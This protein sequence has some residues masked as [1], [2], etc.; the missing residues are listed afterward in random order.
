LLDSAI[1]WA[2]KEKMGVI[3]NLMSF[4]YFKIDSTLAAASRKEIE[5]GKQLDYWRQV[6]EYFRHYGDNVRLIL[7]EYPP[8]LADNAVDYNAILQRAFQQIR[9]I[10]TQRHFYVPVYSWK[11]MNDFRLPENSSNISVAFSLPGIQLFEM[12]HAKPWFFPHNYPRITFPAQLPDLKTYLP[13]NATA[14]AYSEKRLDERAI[15]SDFNMVKDMLRKN[16]VSFSNLYIV[17]WGYYVGYPFQPESVEDTTSIRNY[18]QAMVTQTE[19]NSI[20]WSIYDYNSGMA[21][22]DSAGNPSVLLRSLQLKKGL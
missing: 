21:I 3:F 15:E 16:K 9:L 8:D 13:E 17:N 5:L 19:R 20:N 6:T 12:Q 10:D 1:R 14:M 22:R 11:Q 7:F 4:P 18:G 2:E